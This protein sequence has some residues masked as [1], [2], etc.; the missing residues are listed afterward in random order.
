MLLMMSKWTH[1]PGNQ[2]KFAIQVKTRAWVFRD[3]G[4]FLSSRLGPFACSE[5]S[6]ATPA[7]TAAPGI[8]AIPTLSAELHRETASPVIGSV[9]VIRLIPDL[10]EPTTGT[11]S[12][13][14]E[15]IV[16]VVPR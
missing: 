16:P 11:K 13:R 15:R 4:T 2:K 9:P 3:L 5:V 12:V 1:C 8:I 10:I 7:A 14:V 6:F